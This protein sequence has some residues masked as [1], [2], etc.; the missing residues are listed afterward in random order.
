MNICLKKHEE[1]GGWYSI[2]RVE[3]DG[4]EWLQPVGENCMQFMMSERLSPEACIEG[5]REEM[6]AIA[7]AI[8][9]KSSASFKRCAV[10]IDGDTAYFCSPK[11]SK[12]DVGIP[13]NFADAF[14]DHVFFELSA[15]NGAQP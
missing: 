11:N 1:F 5:D 3:H 2:V 10:R 15:S 12:Q 9:D 8:K 13:I 14:A 4:R 6:L 7:N